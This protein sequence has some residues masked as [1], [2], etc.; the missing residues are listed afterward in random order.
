[1]R[2]AFLE[3][4][5]KLVAELE[6]ASHHDA[7]IS[8]AQRLLRHEPLREESYHRLMNLYV[9]VGNRA[10]APIPNSKQRLVSPT[11]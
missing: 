11:L 8:C 3:V 7:A 2:G 1:L 5:E 6:S 9:S 10:G 4:L